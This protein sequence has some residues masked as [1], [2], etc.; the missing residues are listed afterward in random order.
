MLPQATT[1]ALLC[2]LL[3]LYVGLT[4]ASIAA[5][6]EST[7][8]SSFDHGGDSV[9]SLF[10]SFRIRFRTWSRRRHRPTPPCPTFFSVCNIR[11]ASE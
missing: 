9:F 7:P 10:F 8:S 2:G 1:G 3:A 4:H 5:A 11:F 6:F